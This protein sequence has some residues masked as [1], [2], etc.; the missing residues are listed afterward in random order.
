MRPPLIHDALAFG[1]AFPYMR[2]MQVPGHIDP[3]PVPR[4][5]T[6]R[7]DGRIDL[8]GPKKAQISGCLEQG[9]L[10]GEPGKPRFN[11]PFPCP[12][13]GGTRRKPC[14]AR[15]DRFGE[16]RGAAGT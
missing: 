15:V 13:K 5:V 9:G 7:A 6:P 4:A 14:R 16:D 2:A 3:V 1:P 11:K 12:Y 8:L 10:D